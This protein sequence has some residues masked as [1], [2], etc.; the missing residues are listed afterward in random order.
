M[1]FGPRDPRHIDIDEFIKLDFNRVIDELKVE[2]EILKKRLEVMES[3]IGRQGNTQKE[4]E[5]KGGE[6]VKENGDDKKGTIQ[7]TIE[8]L[9]ETIE[10]YRNE[11]I[12]LKNFIDNVTD[13]YNRDNRYLQAQVT[14]NVDALNQYQNEYTKLKEQLNKYKTKC[15]EQATTI[16]ACFK[17]LQQIKTKYE[18]KLD[19]QRILIQI[20]DDRMRH[21]FSQQWD[22]KSRQKCTGETERYL[23]EKLTPIVPEYWGLQEKIEYLELKFINENRDRLINRLLFENEQLRKL[24]ENDFSEC[25]KIQPKK[26][27]RTSEDYY[28]EY[29]KKESFHNRLLL[30][31]KERLLKQKKQKIVD[32]NAKLNF[33]EYLHN[34]ES[35]KTGEKSREKD[36]EEVVESE[37]TDEEIIADVEDGSNSSISDDI[38]HGSIEDLK[39][40]VGELFE[41]CKNTFKGSQNSFIQSGNP[42]GDFR[43]NI[44]DHAEENNEDLKKGRGGREVADWENK[45]ESAGVD[46][47]NKMPSEKS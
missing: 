7:K 26:R 13:K 43:E 39:E 16:M 17:Y 34:E 25:L 47:D 45:F 8:Q 27:V 31:E 46:L 3:H 12:I 2:N 6:D 36:R 23:H 22:T 44:D 11:T 9:V 29:L 33:E 32:M 35:C 4:S 42:I 40:L 37:E 15:D 14:F 24:I 41:D 20:L 38:L 5:D 30:S 21:T 19:K 10:L 1:S 28:V 18:D